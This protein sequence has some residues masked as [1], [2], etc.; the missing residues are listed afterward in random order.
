MFHIS[1]TAIEPL[2]AARQLSDAQAG[3]C[4]TFEGWVREHNDG[5]A[6]CQL[7]Y[8]AYAELAE[9]EGAKILAEARARFSVLGVAGIHRVGLLQI[10][11]LAMWVGVVA[12]HRGAAFEAC[13]Y[14]IDEAKARLPIWK[15]EHYAGGATA[16]INCAVRGGHAGAPRA[17]S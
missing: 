4:V 12:A 3:A 5:R 17:G 2:A 11:E 15:K 13:R 14:I 1:R 9:R 16:W 10:G 6:V 8:E 7:E